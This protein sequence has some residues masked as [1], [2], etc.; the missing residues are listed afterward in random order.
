MARH[1][2]AASIICPSITKM[3]VLLAGCILFIPSADSAADDL[4]SEVVIPADSDAPGPYRH[5]CMFDELDNG[6]L[7]MECTT[8]T[9]R[10]S[11]C[12]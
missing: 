4:H 8:T 12:R 7:Y 1:T 3:T 5:P 9:T 6:D 10:A 2:K 11:V